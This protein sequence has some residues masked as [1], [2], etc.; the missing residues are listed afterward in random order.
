MVV[1]VNRHSD[2][3]ILCDNCVAARLLVLQV[4]VRV[5]MFSQHF[6]V[7]ISAASHSSAVQLCLQK[8]CI[9]G[10]AVVSAVYMHYKHL[11]HVAL[12]RVMSR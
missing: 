7:S 1:L 6:G 9:H 5:R 11:L 10:N 2:R 8:R 3:R 4:T 12:S